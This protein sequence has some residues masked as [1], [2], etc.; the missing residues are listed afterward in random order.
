MSANNTG[1]ASVLSN[2]LIIEKKSYANGGY[3]TIVQTYID[4]EFLIHSIAL[5]AIS[6]ASFYPVIYFLNK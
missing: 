6:V 3:E 1:G 5:C 2:Q 4:D